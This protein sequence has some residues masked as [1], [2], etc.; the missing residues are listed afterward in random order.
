MGG[1][2]DGQ[3]GDGTG[4][5]SHHPK[6]IVAASNVTA[7]AAGSGYSLFIKSDGSLWA[8]GANESGELGDGGV[9]YGNPGEG[10][11]NSMVLVPEQVVGSNV[12]AVAAGYQRNYIPKE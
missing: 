4:K 1:N 10:G 6:Q 9:R 3:L 8:M 2:G 7:V 5:D 11:S 12:T